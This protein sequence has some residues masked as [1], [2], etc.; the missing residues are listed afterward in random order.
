M[1]VGFL[2]G[3]SECDKRRLEREAAG[4]VLLSCLT[5]KRM[6]GPR[7]GLIYSFSWPLAGR[8]EQHH[9]VSA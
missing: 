5:V 1:V 8:S 4:S 3:R 7:G 6:D 9:G 2:P